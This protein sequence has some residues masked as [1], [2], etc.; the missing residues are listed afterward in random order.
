MQRQ[1]INFES[2]NSAALSCA[3]TLLERWLP[4]GRIVG[5]EYEVGDLNGNKGSSLKINMRTGKWSDFES[6]ESG[7]DLISLYAAIHKIDQI[8]AAKQVAELVGV[9]IDDIGNNV[10][11]ASN[12]GNK[13]PKWEPVH[14]THPETYISYIYI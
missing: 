10:S 3:K 9:N 6:G 11:S 2:I 7:G 8:E 1:S 12:T 4:A 13:K 5:A 14:C